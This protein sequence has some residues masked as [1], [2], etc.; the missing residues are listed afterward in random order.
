[1]HQDVALTYL[2]ALSFK[3]FFGVSR[4]RSCLGTGYFSPQQNPEDEDETAEGSSLYEKWRRAREDRLM[5]SDRTHIALI[6][7]DSK[8]AGLLR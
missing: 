4:Y 5:E 7:R 8:K 2:V 1:M 3:G 6:A